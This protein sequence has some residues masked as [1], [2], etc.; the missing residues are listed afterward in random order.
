MDSTIQE[1]VETVA[2]SDECPALN[3]VQF[4]ALV[5]NSDDLTC[6]TV[7]ELR[8]EC[9]RLRL[10]VSGTKASLISKLTKLQR[11]QSAPKP[12]SSARR[13]QIAKQL[14]HFF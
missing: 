10:P 4:R 9:T 2:D 6:L 13:D 5:T 1:E 11:I 12:I 8:E 7:K 3:Q 14:L